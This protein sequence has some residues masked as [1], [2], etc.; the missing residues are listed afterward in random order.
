MLSVLSSQ[1]KARELVTKFDYRNLAP[2][3]ANEEMRICIRKD[4]SRTDKYDVWIEGRD[5]GY[6]VRG[7]A[8]IGNTSLSS[9]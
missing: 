6:A 2:L 3:Y 5:G 1:L 9:R 4:A 8:L 7:S